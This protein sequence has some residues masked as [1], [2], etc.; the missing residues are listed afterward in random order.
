MSAATMSY[1]LAHAAMS[2]K[3]SGVGAYDT[4][5][6]RWAGVGPYYAMFPASFAD[7]VIENYSDVGDMVLDPFAGRG[8]ALFSAAVQ[9]RVGIGIEV[10]PV[11][12]VYAQAKLHTAEE[13]DVRE[14]LRSVARASWRFRAEAERLPIFYK[15]CFSP[16]VR[17]FLLAARAMLNWRQ[18]SIDWTTSALLM[19]NMHGKREA[20]LSNQMRQTKAMSPQYAVAWWRRQKFR[21]PN[22]DPLEFMEDRLAW[23]YARGRPRLRGSRVYLGDSVGRLPTLREKIRAR[24]LFTSPP[25]CGVTNS[26]MTSGSA[27]GCW[28]VHQNRVARVAHHKD[29]FVTAQSTSSFFRLSLKRRNN[30]S[31][32]MQ[33]FTCVPTN[34]CSPTRSLGGFSAK[35][36]RKNGCKLSPS[37]SLNRRKRVCLANLRKIQAKSI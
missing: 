16:R 10:N 11:G 17:T 36:F 2:S 4:A 7:R 19:V 26:T 29:G 15:H 30:S 14:R 23:R 24:L 18:C 1:R 37:R 33:L 3:Q 20:S 35:F 27:F 5:E 31:W 32:K 34:V 13:S 6:R 25:Y 12:W 21:P 28:A 8:T 9:G 22:L